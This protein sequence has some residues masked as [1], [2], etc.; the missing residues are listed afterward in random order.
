MYS[1]PV[2]LKKEVTVPAKG[3]VKVDFELSGQ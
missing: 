2:T 1:D 3:D